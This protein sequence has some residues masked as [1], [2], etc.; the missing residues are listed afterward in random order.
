MCLC[1]VVSGGGR[2][3]LFVFAYDSCRRVHNI[4]NRTRRRNM[5][6]MHLACGAFLCFLGAACGGVD[7]VGTETAKE[8][9]PAP[10]KGAS[11]HSSTS[12]ASTMTRTNTGIGTWE[13]TVGE[14][15]YRA[16]GRGDDGRSIVEFRAADVDACSQRNGKLVPTESKESSSG[17]LV[18]VTCATSAELTSVD[19]TTRLMWQ[20]LALD[21]GPNKGEERAFSASPSP[22]CPPQTNLKCCGHVTLWCE[23]QWT[24]ANFECE[25][26]GWYICGGCWHWLPTCQD[27]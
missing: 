24:N 23:D 16:V 15:G 8:Q 14:G 10:A 13:I 7:P 9:G 2:P 25:T 26:S 1:T 18:S 21:T 11:G 5:K 4:S 12:A 6:M 19:S 20:R 22:S 3:D 17:L 27:L